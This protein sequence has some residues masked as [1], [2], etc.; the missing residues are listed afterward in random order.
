[1]AKLFE[2]MGYKDPHYNTAGFL[3]GIECEIEA[4]ETL[5]SPVD[6][7]F[8]VEADGSLRNNGV[9]YISYPY[10]KETLLHAFKKLHANLI[11]S[12]K[13]EAFSPRTSTH[14]HI[15]V[16]GLES[17]ELRQLMLFYALYEE[18]FFAMVDA[19]RRQNIHCVALT[20]TAYPGRYRSD[21]M[22]LAKSW[23]KYTAFNM[24]PVMTQGTVEFRHLQGTDD[25]MLLD[26]WLSTIQNLYNLAQV[27]KISRDSIVD[28]SNLKRWYRTI[29]ADAPE[30]LQ[31][32]P[33]MHNKI[34]NSLIDVKMALL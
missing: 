2:F 11:F 30:I 26:R 3:A 12:D 5:R 21:I 4:V 22:A 25:A 23:H 18:F 34:Q 29:F 17:N 15:N 24:Q 16:R 20:E 33:A 13:N 1:M 32:E 28:E 10:E 19:K 8:R 9:E 14:V 7:Y 31:L 27:D 6:D